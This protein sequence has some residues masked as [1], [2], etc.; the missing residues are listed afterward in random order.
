MLFV[1]LRDSTGLVQVVFNPESNKDLFQQAETLR[2]EY[3]IAVRDGWKNG[4]K[5]QSTL[6]CPPASEVIG[7]GAC[8]FKQGQNPAF[9]D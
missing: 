8:N 4:Q 2:N 5:R 6:T 9:T 7:Q 1:D 3:V